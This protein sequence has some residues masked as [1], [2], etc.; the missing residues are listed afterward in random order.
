MDKRNVLSQTEHE[1]RLL[2]LREFFYPFWEDDMVNVYDAVI[3]VLIYLLNF[4]RVERMC[5]WLTGL[6]R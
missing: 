1:L 5:Y 4:A 6:K 2:S 3:C